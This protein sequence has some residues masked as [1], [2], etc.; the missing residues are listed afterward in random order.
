MGVDASEV[1]AM[2]AFLA[3]PS[4]HSLESLESMLGASGAVSLDDALR[5]ALT[6]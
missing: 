6:S 3:G 2:V 1:G 4:H 5:D